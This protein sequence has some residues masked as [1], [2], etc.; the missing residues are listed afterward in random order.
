MNALIPIPARTPAAR[1]RSCGQEIYF[2][3]HPS[4]GRMHPVSVEHEDAERPT[5][6]SE[7]QG[8]S[9]FADCPNADHHR[10]SKR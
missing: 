7:G 10:R 1:C 6:L 9:H 8:I 5:S 2:A 3:P 4:T